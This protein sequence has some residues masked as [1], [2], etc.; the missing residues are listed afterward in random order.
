MEKNIEMIKIN[1]DQKDKIEAKIKE[2]EAQ[3][4]E[5]NKLKL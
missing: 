2:K 5:G 3:I 1:L 4:K